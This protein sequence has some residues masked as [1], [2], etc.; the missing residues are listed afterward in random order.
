MTKYGM[1][2]IIDVHSLPSGVNGM[3]FGEAEGPRGI[4]IGS[5]AKQPW[6]THST[7]STRYYLYAEFRNPGI[8]Q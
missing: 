3:P 2:V 4:S 5:R 1:R 6:T 7:L 8:A